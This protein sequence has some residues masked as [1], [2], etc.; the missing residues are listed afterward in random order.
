[1]IKA[2]QQ[3]SRVPREAR[4]HATYWHAHVWQRFDAFQLA[5]KAAALFSTMAPKAGATLAST[6]AVL[7]LLTH[8]AE[9]LSV[10]SMCNWGTDLD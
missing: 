9:Q 2:D 10:T 8:L 3:P 6:N 7:L 5:D 1:M 4:Q